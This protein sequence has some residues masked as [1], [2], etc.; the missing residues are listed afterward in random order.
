MHLTSTRRPTADTEDII[1]D[2]TRFFGPEQ[3]W[4]WRS[5]VRKLYTHFALIILALLFFWFR[6]AGTPSH[7]AGTILI[8]PFSLDGK[9]IKTSNFVCHTVDI[10]IID[11]GYQNSRRT[12]SCAP[13]SKVAAGILRFYQN[14]LSYD[15]VV[16][17]F[18]P[19]IYLNNKRCK[20]YTL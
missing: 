1:T 20:I 12:R 14:I 4:R 17:F 11:R 3:L 5:L 16:R 7:C 19:S 6:L 18:C 13:I 2:T 10:R 8:Q 9:I 15:L